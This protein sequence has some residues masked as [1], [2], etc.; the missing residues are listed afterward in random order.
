MLRLSK[1]LFFA[2]LGAAAITLVS[3]RAFAITLPVCNA[4]IN[5]LVFGDFNVYSLPLLN[6]QAGYGTVPGPGDPYF[7]RSTYGQ[8]QNYTIIGINNGQSTN[9]GNPPGS[10]DGSYDTPSQNNDTNVTFSTLSAA[11]PGGLN[12]FTG[13]VQSWDAQVPALLSL[14]GGTPLTAYFAFNETGSGTG[15]LT[16]D[17]LIWASATLTDYN[18]DGTIGPNG[19]VTY[20][21]GGA[22]APQSSTP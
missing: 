11:D 14:S 4:P 16:T 17:L 12:E 2:L 7:V 20:Y 1:R 8:I 13:D 3:G 10:V 21:L 22:G 9:T 5:C 6:A 15:L 18:P 19:S